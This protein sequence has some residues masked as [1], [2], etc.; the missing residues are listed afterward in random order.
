LQAS[1]SAFQNANSP[2][3]MLKIG[4]AGQ[5]GVAQIVDFV[6]GVKGP[7][8]GAVLIEWNL[9][10]PANAPGKI[11]SEEEN[12]ELYYFIEFLLSIF[13]NFF[14]QDW[15]HITYRNFALKI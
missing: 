5:T 3:P 8:P 14:E 12:I 2:V 9:H 13:C 10:D 11:K 6:I 15:N 7:Q 4:T 1:G